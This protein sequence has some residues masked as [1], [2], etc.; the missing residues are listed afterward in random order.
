MAWAGGMSGFFSAAS[1][2][3]FNEPSKSRALNRARASAGCCFDVV[4]AWGRLRLSSPKIGSAA[5][6]E[7]VNMAHTASG[8]T[9]RM[10][11]VRIR[12]MMKSRLRGVKDLPKLHRCSESCVKPQAG[13]Y[14]GHPAP[15]PRSKAS[16][17]RW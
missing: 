10:A 1:F 14:F 12:F 3:S 7:I 5:D 8:A 11:I 13:C 15:T 17:S 16:W 9:V 4:S 2:Q 6:R